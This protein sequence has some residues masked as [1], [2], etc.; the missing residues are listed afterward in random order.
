MTARSALYRARDNERCGRVDA[1]AVLRFA[2]DRPAIGARGRDGGRWMQDPEDFGLRLVGFADE[3]A[4]RDVDHAGW[5]TYE[6]CAPDET[7]RGV[8]YAL[9]ARRGVARYVAGYVAGYAGLW[10]DGVTLYLGKALEAPGDEGR[11]G[12]RDAALM[13][14]ERARCIA[15]DMREYDAAWHAGQSARELASEATAAA[16]DYAKRA[17]VL[18][19]ATRDGAAPPVVAVLREAAADAL[20]AFTAAR[21]AARDAREDRPCG[22]VLSAWCDGYA[23]G[24]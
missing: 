8:V 5:H 12:A 18:R 10:G 19:V 4:P 22:D 1:N 14:D 20:D 6:H 3:V 16:S 17:R 13:A 21:D 15:E 9:P 2:P 23:C 24:A 7:V 11:D